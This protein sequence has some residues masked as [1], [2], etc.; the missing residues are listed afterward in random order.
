MLENGAWFLLIGFLML[1]RGLTSTILAR[2]PFS[3]SIIYLT[4]GVIAGPM[5][6]NLF[7]FDPISEAPLLEILSEVAVLISLFSAGIKMPVPVTV[8]QWTKPILLAW[9]SMTLTVS[10]VAA[11]S[12][13]IFNFPIGLAILL[14][15]ILAPT[16]PVLATDVQ[17]RHAG[18]KDQ[19]RFTLTC[20][21]GMND[22]SA[23]PFVMLGLGLLG[24]H[25]LG[26]ST[27]KWVAVDV[28]WATSSA[29]II[30]ILAGVLLA[31]AGLK[32][33]GSDL[34][35]E[36]LDDLV[37]L[38]LIA[39]VYGISLSVGAW[40]FLAVFFAGVALRQRE[41]KLSERRSN[42]VK[43][44]KANEEPALQNS[45][46][47][48]PPIIS[49]EA[50][51]FGAHLERLSE[52]LLVFLLGGMLAIQ[53]WNWQSV[54]LAIFLFVVAR[55]LSVYIGLIGT[56]TTWKL[57]GMIGWFGVRG[58]G[59][60]YYLMYAIQHGIDKAYASQLTQLTLVVITLSIILHGTSVKPIM[61]KFWRRK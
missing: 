40:G 14:G 3:S 26:D 11:F 43:L 10:F 8:N 4:I 15:A 53:F 34:K 1:G 49:V 52:M 31:H 48:T 29:V 61:E 19:L 44:T 47:S 50:L 38:G 17:S 46:D 21:A 57:R 5:V 7:H 59:S 51:V 9:L 55:P 42:E 13:F 56:N 27:L 33:R 36:V 6:L 23:F 16:D 58:I 35:H 45:E 25:N 60:I 54:T 12:Y 32:L 39:I 18:D 30:G 37:G 41:L 24:L 22:G 20:E 2:S 28:V